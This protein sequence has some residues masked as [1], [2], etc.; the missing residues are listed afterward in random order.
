VPKSLADSWLG[1]YTAALNNVGNREQKLAEAAEAIETDL[2]PLGATAIED[3]L[4]D[5]VPEAIDNLS[6]AGCKIWMLTGKK[7]VW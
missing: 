1:Q 4:Q 2:T 7:R 3:R 5:G 6:K